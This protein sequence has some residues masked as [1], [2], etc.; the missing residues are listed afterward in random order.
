ML[1]VECGAFASV[2]GSAAP[3]GDANSMWLRHLFSTR[4]HNRLR[5]IHIVV[6]ALKLGFEFHF[7]LRKI[8]NA[9]ARESP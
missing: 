6:A 4:S 9:P 1:G 5:P 3:S 8:D 7:E 2:G